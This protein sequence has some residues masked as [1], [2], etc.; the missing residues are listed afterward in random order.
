MTLAAEK[1][2][3]VKAAAYEGVSFREFARRAMNERAALIETEMSLE[4][5]VSRSVDILDPQTDT[6]CVC[7]HSVTRHVHYS[8]GGKPGS[9]GHAICNCVRYQQSA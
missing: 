6:V 8:A 5:T 3:W 9:C 4:K 7:G 2:K 1:T